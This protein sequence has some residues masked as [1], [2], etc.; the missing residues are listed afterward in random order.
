MIVEATASP[1]YSHV[2]SHIITT[3]RRGTRTSAARARMGE[4]SYLANG[5]SRSTPCTESERKGIASRGCCDCCCKRGTAAALSPFRLCR[6]MGFPQPLTSSA[7]ALLRF[8]AYRGWRARGRGCERRKRGLSGKREPGH[9]SRRRDVGVDALFSLATLLDQDRA[10]NP[11]WLIAAASTGQ[12][13][14]NLAATDPP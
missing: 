14:D 11:E 5:G 6:T 1:S 2:P 7:V 8:S 12:R 9:G 4:G 13:I 3:P 10:K